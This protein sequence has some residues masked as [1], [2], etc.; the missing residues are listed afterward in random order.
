MWCN[1]NI[2][3]FLHFRGPYPCIKT[4]W[5]I[6]TIRGESEAKQ[7]HCLENWKETRA[8]QNKRKQSG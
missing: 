8:G 5:S 7:Q 3:F 6:H 1:N 2:V 4:E